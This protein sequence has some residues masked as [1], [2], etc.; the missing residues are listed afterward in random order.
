MVYQSF[1]IIMSTDKD[2]MFYFGSS[3][4]LWLQVKEMK[5]KNIFFLK[6]VLFTG[7]LIWQIIETYHDFG[8]NPIL[9]QYTIQFPTLDEII[10]KNFNYGFWINCMN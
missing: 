4:S 5:F 3:L 2:S 6:L 9:T 10:F 7:L 8:E 1:T